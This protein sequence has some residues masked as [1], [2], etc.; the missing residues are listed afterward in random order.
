MDETSFDFCFTAGLEAMRAG[1]LDEAHGKLA[2]LL[3]GHAGELRL[4]LA[5]A[6]AE[7]RRGNRE[8]AIAHY[9]SALG[10]D[11]NHADVEYNLGVLHVELGQMA[12][13]ETHFHRAMELRPGWPPAYNSLAK[14]HWQAGRVDE[15]MKYYRLSA[16]SDPRG[17]VANYNLGILYEEQE[18]FAEAE[19]YL[20]TA[21]ELM[22]GSVEILTA[23]G[24]V[25][26]G[27]LRIPEAR[28]CFH[29][30]M[31]LEASVDESWLTLAVACHDAGMSAEAISLFQRYL[32]PHPKR[33]DAWIG[34]GAIFGQ[35]GMAAEAEVCYRRALE[36]NPNI[37]LAQSNL[38]TA[39]LQQGRWAE[40][41]AQ[42]RSILK[43]R[44]DG[45]R[46]K[47]YLG[48]AQLCQGHWLEGWENN[49]YRWEALELSK[50]T[51]PWPEWQGEDLA[52]KH[53]LL[54]SEQ[55]NGDSIM[56]FRYAEHLAAR[57]GR[58]TVLVREALQALFRRDHPR[59]LVLTEEELSSRLAD[60]SLPKP[61]FHCSLMELLRL[62]AVA[63]DTI[64][65]ARPYLKARP[66][67]K[68]EALKE[69]GLHVGIVWKG[70]P[71]FADDSYRSVPHF[72]ALAPLL[73]IEGVHLHSL[74]VGSGADELKGTAIDNPAAGFKTFDDTAAY[75]QHLDLVLSVDT[76][77]A[78]L[79]GAMGIPVWLMLPLVP[80][81]R[82]Y[83]YAN[84]TR[85]YPSARLFYQKE[86]GEAGW[87]ELAGRLA[88]ELR[89]LA[90]SRRKRTFGE[91][92]YG[93][94]LSLLLRLQSWQ[95]RKRQQREAEEKAELEKKQKKEKAP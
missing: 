37:P 76:S 79:A 17:V 65:S 63:P 45:P 27:R 61:D 70:S 43:D 86:R 72:R 50:P 22:P 46:A 5:L 95:D 81:W 32:K 38:A 42:C 16:E 71:S 53:L 4:H 85:W 52:G 88:G 2:A 39:L 33:A 18:K 31:G 40:A 69:K 66:L 15:A 68:P 60:G 78:H 3:P 28:E 21:L 10:I 9:Q 55:G 12:G 26:V 59:L 25:L 36:L 57:G 87:N 51:R 89:K 91:W 30:A 48:H 73:G 58:V 64:L 93:A 75:L 84:T 77:V 1:R 62:L 29:K 8:A 24:K 67:P 94:L 13:A 49:V 82:W 41:E 11:P 14:V 6:T 7:T 20:R 19:P 44:P 23:L 56:M 74:Q 80:E 34:L 92:F 90:A 54:W 35:T 47:Y 83:P